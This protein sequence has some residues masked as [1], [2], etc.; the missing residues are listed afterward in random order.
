MYSLVMLS[1]FWLNFFCIL[2]Q[3]G[4]DWNDST[5]SKEQVDANLQMKQEAATRRERALAYAYTHQVH[6]FFC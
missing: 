4:D 3:S 6:T 2:Q 1:A 5:R